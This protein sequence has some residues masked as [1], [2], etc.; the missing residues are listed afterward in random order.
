MANKQI[1]QLPANTALSATDKFAIQE[2]GGTTK[3][4][5]GQMISD[6]V[7][8]NL[9][10]PPTGDNIYNSNGTIE[11]DRI[12]EVEDKSLTFRSVGGGAIY[13]ELPFAPGSGSGVE[14]ISGTIPTLGVPYSPVP[15]KTTSG[16]GID[17]VFSVGTFNV[18]EVSVWA[19][20]F[21]GTP[22]QGSGFEVG[23]IIVLSGADLGGVD[24]ADDLTITVTQ[25]EESTVDKITID[26]D[27]VGMYKNS[28]FIE[29]TGAVLAVQ[30]QL[31]KSPTF[32]ANYPGLSQYSTDGS[33]T[34]VTFDIDEYFKVITSYVMTIT[35]GGINYEVGDT[36]VVAGGDIG[37]TTPA[38]NKTFLI[39]SVSEG[40]V[41][42][43]LVELNSEGIDIGMDKNKTLI[44]EGST[45]ETIYGADNTK[46]ITST[47]DFLKIEIINSVD[48]KHFSSLVINNEDSNAVLSVVDNNFGNSSISLNTVGVNIENVYNDT[49]TT[50][51]IQIASGIELSIYDGT[52]QTIFGQTIQGY[53]YRF[54]QVI[55]TTKQIQSFSDTTSN[56]TPLTMYTLDATG[57]SSTVQNFNV[58]VFGVKDDTS[59][60]YYGELNGTYKWTSGT[61]SFL[62]TVDKLEK[63]QFT[64]ATSNLIISGTEM[65]VQVTG[66][67]A[68]DITW[69]IVIDYTG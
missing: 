1:N 53:T 20:E 36:I 19:I 11:T 41:L 60:V 55:Q 17:A 48:H 66:E 14:Y 33:G 3:N 30:N 23:D 64:T 25:V 28:D 24:G 29:G 68:T 61:L 6:F 32:I 15:I 21:P 9:P 49:N 58:K 54:G 40:V 57:T 42:G 44:R 43:Q 63:T 39:T 38:G 2:A 59:K 56:A 65:I 22:S 62:G 16:S 34:G 47:P 37:L 8:S 51:S 5:T 35:S 18:G 67:A 31:L 10:T 7:E 13:L 50:T 12:V 27:V 69:K 26:Q 52:N 45:T 4:V 46:V